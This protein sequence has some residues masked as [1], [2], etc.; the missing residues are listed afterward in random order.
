LDDLIDGYTRHGAFQLGRADQ[1]GS[2]EVG[3]RADLVVLDRNL[4]EVDRYDI[5]NTR[6]TAVMMD[7]VLVHGSLNDISP[8]ARIRAAGG[9]QDQ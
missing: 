5:H 2:I 4:F 7:G 9:N 3:K 1:L 8:Q 6:P